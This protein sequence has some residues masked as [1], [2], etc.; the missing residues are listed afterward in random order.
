MRCDL[1]VVLATYNGAQ[2]LPEQLSSLARQKLLPSRLLVADDGSSDQSVACVDAFA[3]T[4]PFP[5]VWISQEPTGGPRTNFSR[6]LA[7]SSAEYVALCDQDD[8]WDADKL[9]RSMA[10]LHVMAQ[11]HGAKVPLCVHGDL[12]VVDAQGMEM[13]SSLHRWRRVYPPRDQQFR[14]MLYRSVLWGCTMVVNRPLIDLALPIPPTAVM[15]DYWL[16]LVASG[17]G[18]IGCEPSARI[19]YRFHGGNVTESGAIPAEMSGRITYAAARLARRRHNLRTLRQQATTFAER[20]GNRTDFHDHPAVQA[21]LRCA[22]HAH[23]SALAR[24]LDL[25][26]GDFLGPQISRI[27]TG[28]VIA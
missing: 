6:L 8:C 14:R 21:A 5:V 11:R 27:I 25:L 15:H 10:R 24:R 9:A 4:A 28:L 16:A 12:R 23:M 2:Y 17:F 1:E 3:K 22:S 26:K 13:S 18:K 20:Y 7:A 19:S